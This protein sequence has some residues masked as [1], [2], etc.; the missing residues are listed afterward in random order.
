MAASPAAMM[1]EQQPEK[2]DHHNDDTMIVAQPDRVSDDPQPPAATHA[3]T[4][5][6]PSPPPVAL[7]SETDDNHQHDVEEEHEL[8]MELDARTVQT[9]QTLTSGVE[10]V[11]WKKHVATTRRSRQQTLAGQRAPVLAKPKTTT[12]TTS[13]PLPLPP[14]TITTTTIAPPVES[15]IVV[16][17]AEETIPTLADKELVSPAKVEEPSPPNDKDD[18][19]RGRME[20]PPALV[21]E[22]NH[23]KDHL[24]HHAR[25][26]SNNNNDKKDAEKVAQGMMDVEEEPEVPAT[27]NVQ[28]VPPPPPER[29]TM[30]LEPEKQ[31]PVSPCCLVGLQQDDDN[32]DEEE[33][34][35]LAPQFEVS[36]IVMTHD[37][38]EE[39]VSCIVSQ[40]D[41][42]EDYSKNGG[43]SSPR[44]SSAGRRSGGGGGASDPP[45]LTSSMAYKRIFL[46][47][48][49]HVDAVIVESADDRTVDWYAP[50]E[51][52][53]SQAGG[54]GTGSIATH[55][56]VLPP[57]VLD[58]YA[59]SS[60]SVI[61]NGGGGGGGGGASVKSGVSRP[62]PQSVVS[63]TAAAAAQAQAAVAV[64]A[65]TSSAVESSHDGSKNEIIHRVDDAT[66]HDHVVVKDVAV[67][68]PCAASNSFSSSSGGSCSHL[69]V[70]Q[71]TEDATTSGESEG[72]KVI[73]TQKSDLLTALVEGECHD[74][75]T[76]QCH[77]E[78]EPSKSLPGMS[79]QG[80][81]DDADDEDNGEGD[82]DDEMDDQATLD[83]LLDEIIREDESDKMQEVDFILD[84]IVQEDDE[85]E[86]EQGV[87]AAADDEASVSE[88][89]GNNPPSAV[90]EEPDFDV[91]QLET[92]PEAS[93]EQTRVG[94][95]QD[96]PD[97]E[98]AIKP[99]EALEENKD[100][101]DIVDP[102]PGELQQTPV[103][104]KAIMS[105]DNAEEPSH[106]QT[107]TGDSDV[108]DPAPG[109]LQ[110]TPVVEK[111]IM[112][113][114]NAE[115]PSHIQTAEGGSDAVP[116][117]SESRTPV[118]GDDV[119][120]A[121][122]SENNA[123]D[124]LHIQTAE[125]I[126][127]VVPA[128]SEPQTP[129]AE[130][131]VTDAIVSED[132]A[133]DPSH[134][135]TAVGGS[136]VTDLAPGESQTPVIVDD[137]N[138]TIVS[139]DN[140]DDP[141]LI[142][143]AEGSSDV[144]PASSEP[145]TPVA[146]DDINDV[147]VTEDNTDDPSHNQAAEG[148]SNVAGPAP[149]ELRQTPVVEEA[150]MS[151]D[152]AVDPLHMQ[153]A[154]GGS[155]VVPAPSKT[156]T[157]VV[158]DA[159]YRSDEAEKTVVAVSGRD[160]KGELE[161]L[162]ADN[163]VVVSNNR[164]LK[165][166]GYEKTEPLDDAEEKETEPLDDAVAA[167]PV[168]AVDNYSD[169]SKNNAHVLSQSS[170]NISRIMEQVR[171]VPLDDH[172]PPTVA[173]D[174]DAMKCE[175]KAKVSDY[176]KREGIVMN[177]GVKEDASEGMRT[178]PAA[179]AMDED[180]ENEST[181]F[182]PLKNSTDAPNQAEVSCEEV[183]T[184]AEDRVNDVLK[185]S[186]AVPVTDNC[187]SHVEE[188][189]TFQEVQA[190]EE[191]KEDTETSCMAVDPEFKSV[192]APK[193]NNESIE[194]DSMVDAIVA[195]KIRE[196]MQSQ[197]VND[198]ASDGPLSA[199]ALEEPES[200][201]EE[202]ALGYAGAE[203]TI[204]DELAAHEKEQPAVDAHTMVNEDEVGSFPF[205]EL[206]SD[207][208]ASESNMYQN[209]HDDR[210]Q[211]EAIG[212]SE[213]ETIIPDAA[214][215]SV[216]ANGINDCGII[217]VVSSENIRETH[218]SEEQGELEPSAFVPEYENCV[219]SVEQLETLL[220]EA[221]DNENAN[222]DPN[223]AGVI[224]EAEFLGEGLASRDVICAE[225]PMNVHETASE[226]EVTADHC[227]AKAE[228][229]E[230][231]ALSRSER[232]AEVS[233]TELDMDST[234][235][236][237]AAT[238]SLKC[239]SD[240]HG[241]EMLDFVEAKELTVKADI[242]CSG[243]DFVASLEDI[244][245]ANSS[246]QESEP[247]VVA[248]EHYIGDSDIEVPVPERSP[249]AE[250][251]NMK[252]ESYTHSDMDP[253][254]KTV[255]VSI[256]NT[257]RG[258]DKISEKQTLHRSP[259][260]SD[261]TEF[262]VV[263]DL[264]DTSS[265]EIKIALSTTTDTT[266]AID[267]F[268]AQTTIGQVD[269]FSSESSD[270]EDSSTDSCMPGC[271][272]TVKIEPDESPSAQQKSMEDTE[273]AFEQRQ[274]NDEGPDE[275]LEKGESM[276]ETAQVSHES[277]SE[278][279]TSRSLVVHKDR[280]PK[281]WM[282]IASVL[283]V[284]AMVVSMSGIFCTVEFRDHLTP[285][286]K[287]KEVIHVPKAAKSWAQVMINFLE[288]PQIPASWIK[289]DSFIYQTICVTDTGNGK[290]TEME[291]SPVRLDDLKL[292][293]ATVTLVR[294]LP[295][296]FSRK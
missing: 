271:D 219:S 29:A 255:D 227:H 119:N 281:F 224:D 155:D 272:N 258:I 199:D 25:S 21:E 79:G 229:D 135:Q 20:Q 34:E 120:D 17:V 198:R 266:G 261:Q 242:N 145:Q 8:E 15:V 212:A 6:P 188:L 288:N 39:D 208:K 85:S 171:A 44:K 253:Q 24:H 265:D 73:S 63:R 38:L 239:E 102:A 11:A 143:T 74:A 72:E 163:S 67:V 273:L 2:M 157:P 122:V 167:E 153:T 209:L 248:P 53:V 126:S 56:P 117:P 237:V 65:T 112:S 249:D 16:T 213:L 12:T 211:S 114:D 22:T 124:P 14:R 165:T 293:H 254:S 131:D 210:T 7:L 243:V 118:V 69:N 104:E 27:F 98:H 54:G 233:A 3:S 18:E 289:N 100:S 193:E 241:E 108:T 42:V 75:A 218:A 26:N 58:L 41:F 10:S 151:E 216:E 13:P 232:L 238:F 137:V 146:E 226:K 160:I 184:I 19:M 164:Q 223:S 106:I 202:V 207:G 70:T 30:V 263:K 103:V 4:N 257:C 127:D 105:E 247:N 192:E 113:E 177:V 128:R 23:N 170:E 197:S 191:E 101:C 88:W 270:N 133:E 215:D 291:T 268:M 280:R 32:D 97:N 86:A 66:N 141:L 231:D 45:G 294:Q 290:L 274:T 87:L 246:E 31:P 222:F 43:S 295:L 152:N 94:S 64:A 35:E 284:L 296:K 173:A 95:L 225:E 60:S 186:A 150:I 80:K 250:V 180:E 154:E 240:T 149:D 125:G 92:S 236:E 48:G 129:V 40:A 220:N 275:L 140:A 138:D 185:S 116:A 200:C 259:S 201:S 84:E 172:T 47:N 175:N 221:V 169:I 107:A 204:H 83:T 176:V 174:A 251:Q 267:Q 190:V 166:E 179:Q 33:E 134:I 62:S 121:I 59:P 269:S 292:D 147:I 161:K 5:A 178:S 51:A 252:E 76:N 168:H 148:N 278:T 234:P 93:A 139:E 264:E 96:H 228:E 195:G 132:N 235:S 91:S 144:V 277:K 46:Y 189:E 183:P 156:Q 50:S 244:N 142:Q 217:N 82:G 61:T 285:Y 159:V 214:P 158:G 182:D 110:Q 99:A 36:S 90:Y 136:D 49:S 205:H 181:S 130:D 162:E 196:G 123:D 230:V 260:S 81:D 37:A 1:M 203:E 256:P 28:T 283:G 55:P 276:A 287:L 9:V 279:C 245:A 282:K 78:D 71:E 57:S 89:K 68:P 187:D 111:A 262:N 52:S 109:E 77:S 206:S 115:D 194:E 286:L